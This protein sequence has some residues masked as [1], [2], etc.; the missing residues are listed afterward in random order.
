M[1]PSTESPTSIEYNMNN[2]ESQI[3]L[4][5]RFRAACEY[6]CRS[7]F[8]AFEMF[9][10]VLEIAGY[11]SEPQGVVSDFRIVEKQ[12]FLR[13]GRLASGDLSHIY[14]SQ[15]AYAGKSLKSGRVMFDV[16]FKTTFFLW[17]LTT[18]CSWVSIWWLPS[19][20][21]SLHVCAL[22]YRAFSKKDRGAYR[23]KFRQT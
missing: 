22:D 10:F 1:I 6:I 2:I 11:V 20:L 15:M 16:V 14:S 7:R 9:D 21:W 3:L 8:C 19:T 17:C 5:D 4:F 12:S 23:L 18:F 13:R